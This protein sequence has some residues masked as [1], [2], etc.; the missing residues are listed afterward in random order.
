[1]WW[2]N[3]KERDHL[4]DAG[5]GG[6]IIFKCIWRNRI[7]LRGTRLMWFRTET[8]SGFFRIM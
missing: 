7:E 5:E 4:E 2:G 6:R 1:L 3:L 8:G